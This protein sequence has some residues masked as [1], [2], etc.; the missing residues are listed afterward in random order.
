MKVGRQVQ[1]SPRFAVVLRS[2]KVAWRRVQW[3]GP[4]RFLTKWD[5]SSYK[6]ELIPSCGNTV[7][8][9]VVSAVGVQSIGD[10]MDPG[11]TALHSARA[12]VEAPAVNVESNDFTIEEGEECKVQ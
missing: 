9:K 12:Q 2:P 4:A 10:K 7:F 8:G 5:L 11:E 6:T 3:S 1:S